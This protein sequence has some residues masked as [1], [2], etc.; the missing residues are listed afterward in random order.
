MHAFITRVYL[1]AL[2]AFG[3]LVWVKLWHFSLTE[4]M[5]ITIILFLIDMGGQRTSDRNERRS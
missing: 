3:I 1:T 4:G 5:L 2:S